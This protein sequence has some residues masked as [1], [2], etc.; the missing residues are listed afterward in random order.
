L[1]SEH[2]KKLLALAAA[3]LVYLNSVAVSEVQVQNPIEVHQKH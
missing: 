2:Q 3:L 1:L